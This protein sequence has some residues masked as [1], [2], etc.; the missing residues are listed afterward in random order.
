M[1]TIYTGIA[2][3]AL[4]ALGA[5]GSADNAEANNGLT[6][7]EVPAD[8]L[9][10]PPVDNTLVPADENNALGT[11]NDISAIDANLAVDADASGN[12]TNT[13]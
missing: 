10:L 5:C 9:T 3:A 12:V 11:T 8:D 1:K 6:A 2:A 4:L 13:Q 7:T